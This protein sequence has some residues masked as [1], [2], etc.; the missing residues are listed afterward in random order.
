MF[1]YL[2]QVLNNLLPI[3]FNNLWL[4]LY[5]YLA[6][7]GVG[8]NDKFLKGTKKGKILLTNFMTYTQR[9]IKRKY[10]YRR[11][12]LSTIQDCFDYYVLTYEIGA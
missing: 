5:D 12:L 3:R 8:T 6:L 4:A 11:T 7:I 10:F 1:S 2:L 9:F